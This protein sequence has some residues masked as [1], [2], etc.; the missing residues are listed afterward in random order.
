MELSEIIKSR[1]SIRKFKTDEIPGEKLEQM[2]EAARL[3][4]SG[5]NSQPWR[6]VLVKSQEMREE[7]KEATIMPFVHQA[8]V[9]VVCCVDLEA[10][11]KDQVSKRA[12]ELLEAGAFT[13]TPLE[14]FDP[15]AYAKSTS[16][17]EEAARHY[18]RLNA[19]IAV[20]HMVLQAADL[21][22]GTCWVMLFSKK[23]VKHIL[24]LEERYDVLA[25]LPVGYPAQDPPLRP[26]LDL[27][28]ILLKEL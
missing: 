16:M 8:P 28:D 19:A 2:L 18:L 17:E 25:L 12:R 15:D 5:V 22:L 13:G 26:R 24:Q 9:V 20:E 14:D 3:A 11:G 7:L 10:A 23:K 4:P 21:G 6:F 1:R 27:Q